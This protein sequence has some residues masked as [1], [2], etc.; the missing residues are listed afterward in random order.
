MSKR[1]AG[2]AGSW[3]TSNA[4]Q[5]DAQLTEWAALSALVFPGAALRAC[6]SNMLHLYLLR[7]RKCAATAR[8]RDR[9]RVSARTGPGCHRTSVHDGTVIPDA[10]KRTSGATRLPA[11]RSNRRAERPAQTRAVNPVCPD[12]RW[13]QAAK[14]AD[15][16]LPACGVIAP[17]AGYSYS[18]RAAAPLPCKALCTRAR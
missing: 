1:R 6:V 13:L 11:P 4:A 3:Y 14:P 16:M 2:K 8:A 10:H 17:H 7:P 15:G 5:L 9:G 18:V 12:L